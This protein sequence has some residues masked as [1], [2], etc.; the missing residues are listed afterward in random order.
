MV[1]LNKLSGF[2]KR[3]LDSIF[4]RSKL[5]G[6]IED[7]EKTQAKETIE[8]AVMD[9][10]LSIGSVPTGTVGIPNLKLTSTKVGVS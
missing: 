9:E 2:G 10:L 8:D 4:T 5:E 6:M 7:Y 1:D 3:T